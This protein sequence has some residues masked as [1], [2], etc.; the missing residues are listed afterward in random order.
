M[1]R[2]GGRREF[3]NRLVVFG[4]PALI[5]ARQ[6]GVQGAEPPG[7]DAIGKRRDR[8]DAHPMRPKVRA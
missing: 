2:V 6:R 7:D 4:S 5:E 1:R 3:C 8:L